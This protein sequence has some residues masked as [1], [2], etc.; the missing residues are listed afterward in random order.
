MV[1]IKMPIFL[2][3]LITFLIALPIVWKLFIRALQNT[4]KKRDDFIRDSIDKI[5]KDRAEIE[6]MKNDYEKK[7][8]AM[9]ERAREAMNKAVAEG[10][11]M[12]QKAADDAKTEGAKMLDDVK[13][14]INAEKRRAIE[15]VKDIIV[16]LSALAAEKI[17]KKKITKKEQLQIVG[18]HLKDIGKNVN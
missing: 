11:K 15:E 18:R 9:E 16:E 12:K 8:S 5:E 14:E 6:S 17:I 7:L 4:L 2:L 13:K 1:E 3:Q 10:E